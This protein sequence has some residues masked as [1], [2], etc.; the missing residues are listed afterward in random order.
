MLRELEKLTKRVIRKSLKDNTLDYTVQFTMSSTDPGKV[1]YA[2]QISS[3]AAGVQP[4]YF[5][6]DTFNDLKASLEAAEKNLNRK[7]VE[8][9]FHQ[10]RINKYKER[11]QAHEERVVQIDKGEEDEEDIEMEKV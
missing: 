7:E 10:N 5:V 9:V 2:A 11:I 1:Q 8:K 6:F 3:P 4:I